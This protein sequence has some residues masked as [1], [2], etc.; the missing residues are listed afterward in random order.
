MGRVA[1]LGVAVACVVAA[2]YLAVHAGDEAR[3]RAAAQLGAAGRYDAAL[4]RLDGVTREPAAARA[5]RVRA[6]A[7]V[8]AG[9]AGAAQHAFAQAARRSPSD[10]RL[11]RDW[12]LVRLAAGDRPGAARHMRRALALNPRLHLPPGFVRTARAG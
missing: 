2:V 8:G 4:G 3:L 5:W 9:R 6:A 10:W 7:L 12:A 1:A 11:E